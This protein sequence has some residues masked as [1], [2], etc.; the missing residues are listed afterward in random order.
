MLTIREPLP[1][2]TARPMI[3]LSPSFHEKIETNYDTMAGSLKEEELLYLME[4]APQINVWGGGQFQIT[5][6]RTDNRK[7]VTIQTIN[8][9]LNRLLLWNEVNV[10]YQDQVYIE[11]Q[12]RRM[13]VHE[14]SAFLKQVRENCREYRDIYRLTEKY[15]KLG[16]IFREAAVPMEALREKKRDGGSKTEKETQPFA[17]YRDIYRRLDTGKIYQEVC[18]F[19]WNQMAES[20]INARVDETLRFAE[21]ERAGLLLRLAEEGKAALGREQ[22]I[23]ERVNPYELVERRT[24]SESGAVERIKSRVISA[25]LLNLAEQVYTHQLDGRSESRRE[26]TDFRLAF[27]GTTVNTLKRFEEYH[28]ENR[29]FTVREFTF[30]EERRRLRREEAAFLTKFERLWESGKNREGSTED[31]SKILRESLELV[32]EWR[33]KRQEEQE[34]ASRELSGNVAGNLGLGDVELEGSGSEAVVQKSVLKWNE[35]DRE[36]QNVEAGLTLTYLEQK[37]DAGQQTETAGKQWLE[38]RESETE[39]PAFSESSQRDGGSEKSIPDAMME[40]RSERKSVERLNG[41]HLNSESQQMP[42][43]HAKQAD[44]TADTAAIQTPEQIGAQKS[45]PGSRADW[46]AAAKSRENHAPVESPAA[47]RTKAGY[48]EWEKNQGSAGQELTVLEE[49][50]LELTFLQQEMV[51][52]H[53]PASEIVED[54]AAVPSKL[55]VPRETLSR[56]LALVVDQIENLAETWENIAIAAPQMWR[57]PELVREHYDQLLREH[58]LAVWK[59][60]GLTDHETELVK[61]HEVPKAEINLLQEAD[62]Q[63]SETADINV[64]GV[65]EIRTPGVETADLFLALL[66]KETIERERQQELLVKER[67]VQQ[68]TET[69]QTE[70]TMESRDAGDGFPVPEKNIAFR[71]DSDSGMDSIG[72]MWPEAETPSHKNIASVEMELVRN[73]SEPGGISRREDVRAVD[74]FKQIG[75]YLDKIRKQEESNQQWFTGSELLKSIETIRTTVKTKYSRNAFETA[76]INRPVLSEAGGSR[77]II[78]TYLDQVHEQTVSNQQELTEIQRLKQTDLV[79]NTAKAEPVPAR[80]LAGTAEHSLQEQLPAGVNGKEIRTYLD[81]ISEQT[82]SRYQE[83]AKMQLLKV[84]EPL[85]T[86]VELELVRDSLEAVDIPRQ[87]T[88]GSSGSGQEIKQ[89]LDKINEQNILK[90][91]ELSEK[92]LWKAA[93]PIKKVPDMTRMRRESRQVLLDPAGMLERFRNFPSDR[94][95]EEEENPEARQQLEVILK[96]ADDTTRY[97]YEQIWNY[98]QA[99]TPAQGS[100]PVRPA[101]PIQ[102]VTDISR[103]MEERQEQML[104]TNRET[105]TGTEILSPLLGKTENQFRT[106]AQNGNAAEAREPRPV[107]TASIVHKQP[108]APITGELLEQLVRKQEIHVREELKTSVT[109]SVA[110][111]QKEAVKQTE[112]M[113]KHSSRELQALIEKGISKQMGAI[114]EKVYHRLEKKMEGELARRGR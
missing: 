77:E 46:N 105:Q 66:E 95:E 96:H 38:K 5:Q 104:L 30:Q 41:D 60:S 99:G 54:R 111:Q 72:R 10:T 21:Y 6:S 106:S 55:P 39:L 26:W 2:R 61:A 98:N 74:S 97:I 112:V 22:G 13:G 78:K 80:G 53:F 43:V 94:K 110:N 102:L 63:Y 73:R 70:Q 65:K 34:A 28:R 8:Q 47:K 101:A 52:E 19:Q 92:Q 50:P 37:A 88:P 108:S 69:S 3:R 49:K 109:E 84:T 76:G 40:E 90:Y 93:E 42:A 68:P 16:G 71:N 7:N 44:V 56:Q 67:K 23:P 1:L 4:E 33:E 31:F 27:R 18:H 14:V 85:E 20:Q 17:L 58:D 64:E 103:I 87:E 11:R 100:S 75:L 81:T 89:Y 29:R 62:R 24:G 86:E 15:E 107:S 82:A 48:S 25:V 36:E 79:Q 51:N 114:S 32:L 12:L 91:R 57:K 35:T 45:W 113:K 9:V 59:Q 83:F